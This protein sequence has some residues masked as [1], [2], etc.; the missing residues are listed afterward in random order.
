MPDLTNFDLFISYSRHD[1]RQG[2]ISE[3]VALIQKEYRDFTGGEEL[4]VFFDKGELVGMDD[5]QHNT[6]YADFL[7]TGLTNVWRPVIAKKFGFGCFST[8]TTSH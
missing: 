5:W 3:L 6:N 1:N 4:R 2:R 7:D 8:P